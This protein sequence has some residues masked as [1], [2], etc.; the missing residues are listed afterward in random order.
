MCRA[1]H[2]SVRG[3]WLVLGLVTIGCGRLDFEESEDEIAPDGGAVAEASGPAAASSDADES[4]RTSSGVDHASPSRARL[5]VHMS[6]PPRPP[7]RLLEIQIVR[8]S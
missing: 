7:A 1:P 5:A 6:L 8:P 3:T 4:S 2:S